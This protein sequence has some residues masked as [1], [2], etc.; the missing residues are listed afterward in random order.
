VTRRLGVVGH[1]GYE[2]LTEVLT[3][4]RREAP[5]HGFTLRYEAALR[6]ALGTGEVL[7]SPAEID[8]LLALGG[9]GRCCGAPASSTGRR[10]RSSG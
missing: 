9:D 1:L 3:L 8:A 7:S 6:E 4:L 10:S 5:R 2:G